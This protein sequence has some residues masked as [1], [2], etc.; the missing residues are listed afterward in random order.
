MTVGHGVC[1]KFC[2]AFQKQFKGL[3]LS[4]PSYLIKP[5]FRRLDRQVPG[6]PCLVGGE[7]H[8][9]DRYYQ[10]CFKI[11]LEEIESYCP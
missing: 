5:D 2:D 4:F 3:D 1:R 6:M 11:V 10:V 9:I 7:L 8:F